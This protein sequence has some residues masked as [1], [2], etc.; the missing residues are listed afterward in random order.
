MYFPQDIEPKWQKQ[1]HERQVFRAH[2]EKKRKFYC[3]DM[4]P[5]PS[6][7]GLHVGHPEGYTATDI[8]SR[9]K[10]MRGYNV[11]HPMGWDAFG[12]PAENFAIKKGI[13]PKISTQANIKNFRRQIRSFGFSYDW[14]REIDTSTPAYYRWTQWMFLQMY[15]N[16]LAYRKK[17]LVNWC[18]SCQTVLAN[19]QV[20][21]GTCERCHNQV[22]QKELEQWFLK[23]TAYADELIDDLKEL[24]WPEKI[25]TIQR[26][27]IGKKEGLLMWHAIQGMKDTLETFTAYPA[28]V[29]ADTFIVIAPEHPLVEKIIQGTSKTKTLQKYIQKLRNDRAG[30]ARNIVTNEKEGMFTGRYALDP[31]TSQEMPI[32]IANFALMD[33]GTGAIRCSAHDPRDYEF[34]QKYNIPLREVVDRVGDNPVNAHK[35]NGT[36]KNSVQFTGM[37]VTA[38]SVAIMDF[39]EKQGFGKRHTTYKLRDWLISRQRYWGAPI[40]IIYCDTCGPVE[41]PEKNLP[42]LLPDD[43]DFKP[44]GKSP[45]MYSQSFHKVICPQCN[46]SARRESDTMDT[47]VCSSW[48]FLRYTDPQN[49]TAFADAKKMKHWMPVDLY[50]GGVEHAAMHLLYARFFTKALRDFGYV[51]F[52]E[53]FRS[54]RNQGFILGED[55][56]KMSKSR[57]NVVNP[58]EVIE[59]YGA[60]S[61]RLSEMFMG[62]FE[63]TKPWSMQGIKGLYRF[64]QRIYG[65]FE[66]IEKE[67]APSKIQEN[68]NR[69]KIKKDLEESAVDAQLHMTIRKVTNDIESFRFNTAISSMMIFV[70]VLSKQKTISQSSFEQFLKI[71]HPFAPHITDELWSELGHDTLIME[72]AWPSFD[73]KLLQNNFVTIA[74]QMN[75][76]L[77]A[78]MQ[79]ARNT[80]SAQLELLAKQHEKI[81]KIIQGQ[82]MKRIIVVPGKIVNIVT[83]S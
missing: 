42:V 81:H 34:A 79:V 35:N 43:V 9:Y 72:T 40:P 71:L 19:E 27:W 48:Y 32:W 41:V 17:A 26:N 53:P 50:V 64:L 8:V 5:Y 68:K 29:Y 70:N 78:T 31:L 44:T 33:F 25:K 16:K 18:N 10:R 55:N 77:R 12:L 73:V 6:A 4:F 56:Q 37:N 30:G 57:G 52:N 83:E 59:A 65:L 62:P 45:L 24:D 80:T 21:S 75:G 76:K 58:D 67:S 38:A 1:W 51:N 60:D 11:L 39:A 69:K 22:I 7:E 63:D 23:I 47:F 2:D 36:L 15:R 3:L 14:E 49:A 54:L 74:V 13:H 20:A 61:M 66:K 46:K 28:W 82:K